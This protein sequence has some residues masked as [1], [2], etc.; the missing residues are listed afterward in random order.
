[1]K[2]DPYPFK[3]VVVAV[4]WRTG[5]HRTH[6]LKAATMDELTAKAA[7][8]ERDESTGPG[9]KDTHI[10]TVWNGAALEAI[11]KE[12]GD[13]KCSGGLGGILNPKC[14]VHGGSDH[15]A[16]EYRPQTWIQTCPRPLG[17]INPDGSIK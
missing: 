8:A 7:D 17:S 16:E 2:K 13:C 3:A 5:Y 11:N 9:T 14:P 4:Q 10:H 15:R 6:Y 12:A 1:M